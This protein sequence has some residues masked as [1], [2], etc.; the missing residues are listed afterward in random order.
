MATYSDLLQALKGEPLSSVLAT[1]GSFIFVLA[2]TLFVDT[3]NTLSR[4]SCDVVW[5]HEK[6]YG[7]EQTHRKRFV[8]GVV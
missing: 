1:D 4:M 2:V 6:S 3:E 5:T 8:M 7:V